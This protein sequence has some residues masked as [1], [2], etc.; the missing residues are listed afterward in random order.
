LQV[1][2]TQK[3]LGNQSNYDPKVIPPV[4]PTRI[5]QT[6]RTNSDTKV[7]DSQTDFKVMTSR[8]QFETQELYTQISISTVSSCMPSL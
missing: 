8:I 7:S 5:A 3:Y 2:Q 1:L 4:L 6:F